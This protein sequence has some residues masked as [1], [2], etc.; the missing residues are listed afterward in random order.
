M[1][2]KIKL[3]IW[4]NKYLDCEKWI[5]MITSGWNEQMKFYDDFCIH[6]KYKK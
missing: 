2:S 6:C 3:P 5:E 4:C 1:E